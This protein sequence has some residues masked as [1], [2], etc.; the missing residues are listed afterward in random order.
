MR[1]RRVAPLP[2]EGESL[3]AAHLQLHPIH[4]PHGA[5]FRSESGREIRDLQQRVVH[6]LARLR[7]RPTSR[8]HRYIAIES[9]TVVVVVVVIEAAVGKESI[10]SYT[11]FAA[12]PSAAVHAYCRERNT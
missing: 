4:H 10:I 1:V 8:D 6:I 2:E 9:G 7:L 3:A 12:Y 11:R 5:L